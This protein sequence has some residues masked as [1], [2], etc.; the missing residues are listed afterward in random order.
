MHA[1]INTYITHH[2]KQTYYTIRIIHTILYYTYIHRYIHT[3]YYTVYH[4]ILYIHTYIHTYN[5]IIEPI[6]PQQQQAPFFSLLFIYIL[7][8]HLIFLHI[9]V[10]HLLCFILLLLLLHSSADS[11]MLSLRSR[12][13]QLWSASKHLAAS[14]DNRH[15]VCILLP[16]SLFSVIQPFI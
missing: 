9:F 6:T 8:L 11:T 10:N 16:S 15:Q 4:T 2:N 5:A 7:F 14:I 1:Y 13:R 3:L 12:S